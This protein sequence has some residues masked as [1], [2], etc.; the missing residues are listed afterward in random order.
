MNL[1]KRVPE[2]QQSANCYYQK[3]K[4]LNRNG[5]KFYPLITFIMVIAFYGFTSG[6]HSP[7][8]RHGRGGRCEL[9]S[10][11][12]DPFRIND[13]NPTSDSGCKPF[14]HF[15]MLVLFTI[16]GFSCPL[17][18]SANI[19][20]C[21]RTTID[22]KTITEEQVFIDSIFTAWHAPDSCKRL[23][24]YL[25]TLWY[26]R[27]RGVVEVAPGVVIN[28]PQMAKDTLNGF[29][30]ILRDSAFMNFSRNMFRDK[31]PDSTSKIRQ[32]GCKP[33]DPNCDSCDSYYRNVQ[34]Y[35]MRADTIQ[36]PDIITTVDSIYYVFPIT[37]AWKTPITGGGVYEVK[38]PLLPDTNFI[39]HLRV[40]SIFISPSP[41]IYP[42]ISYK[43]CTQTCCPVLYK[44]CF[45][46]AETDPFTGRQGHIKE[47]KV[48]LPR[49]GG[50]NLCIIR[51][52]VF[53]EIPT[54]APPECYVY[55]SEDSLVPQKTKLVKPK[56]LKVK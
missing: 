20:S 18:T 47:V 42:L 12:V 6:L 24:D 19:R 53:S 56:V 26:R 4:N 37:P 35:C 23:R 10:Y 13:C 17:F 45:I 50:N 38:T 28:N 33:N 14:Q 41:I 5:S 48:K 49:A 27:D 55:C 1:R 44:Y 11:P 16:P 25:D 8:L 31:Y 7:D 22:G 52:S 34:G 2:L 3:L 15:K 46:D 32:G 39:S 21:T 54:S 51:D 29:Y 40:D 9:D 36:R 43:T 30:K